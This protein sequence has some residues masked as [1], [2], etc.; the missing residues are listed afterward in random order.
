MIALRHY[1]LA[2]VALALALACSAVRAEAEI[3][4]RHRATQGA[5]T[6]TANPLGQ[7]SRT[8]F[9]SARG[10]PVAAIQPYAQACGF[11]FGMRNHGATKLVARLTDWR[12][13][14]A[15]GR[16]VALRPAEAWDADWA[17]A[18]VPQAARIAFKWA[19]FQTENIFEP[20]DWIMGMAT[21]ETPPS[22]PFRIVARY[23]DSKG[24]HEIVLD[25][26]ACAD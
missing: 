9:Y 8:A 5:V 17:A 24:S 18:G 12:A 23:S 11:S 14:G 10:F 25:R 13:I 22:A 6:L 1:L 2:G 21:L 4:W 7:E 15:D 20:G 19:Q 3:E 26:I 16:Q